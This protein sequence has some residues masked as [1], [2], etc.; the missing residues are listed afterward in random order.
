MNGYK[1]D[2]RIYVVVTSFEPLRIYLYPEGL[3]RFA[4]EKYNLNNDEKE[5]NKFMHLTNWS[6]NRDSEKFIKNQDADV[7]DNG[8]KWYYFFKFI[9]TI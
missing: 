5:F 7:D 3:A 4:T 9:V 6:I 8:S 1:F 2:F